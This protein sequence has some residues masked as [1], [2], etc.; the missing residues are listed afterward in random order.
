M[1]EK[2]ISRIEEI[3]ILI[4]ILSSLIVVFINIMLRYLFSTGFVFAEEYARYTMVL[5]V[6]LAV[7]QAV[8]RGTMIKVD[9]V[10]N[11][12]KRGNI[13]IILLSN[14]FSFI[15]GAILVIFGLQFTVYQYH[16]GQESIAMRL[17]MYIAFA[18]VPLG[19]LLMCFR[20]SINIYQAL[21][22]HF[23]FKKDKETE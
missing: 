12:L 2:A 17:P 3:S 5:L 1:I 7:S 10:S 9:I 4:L 16:T 20:Y 19:G 21:A 18:V 6:Y 8:K 22:D 11:M 14:I 23:S 13:A 15:M